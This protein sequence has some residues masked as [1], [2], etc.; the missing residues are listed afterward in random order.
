MH[1]GKPPWGRSAAIALLALSLSVAACKAGAQPN[2]LPTRAERVFADLSQAELVSLEPDAE[3]GAPGRRLHGWLVLGSMPLRP[4]DA[5][6]AAAAMKAAVA[7]SDGS[8]AAC[9]EPRHA[10]RTRSGGHSYEALIC[11][12][13][14]G[15]EVYRD[16]EYVGGA[17]VAGSSDALNRILAAGHVPVSHSEEV[18]RAQ[19]QAQMANDAAARRRWDAAMPASLRA[20]GED[21]WT[22]E[23]G[24][25]LERRERAL[26][27]E[28]PQRPARILALLRWYGSGAGP[29]SGVAMYEELPDLLLHRYPTEEIIR[30]VE[31]AA[32]T[33]AET[34]GAARFFGG[35]ARPRHAALPPALRGRLL[36]QALKSKDEDKAGRA[37]NAFAAHD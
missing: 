6:A 11:Y 34:E 37:R 22:M 17:A 16:G 35:Y 9:F 18:E 2:R 4:A 26:A 27:Q 1:I 19:M 31:S 14:G 7:A 8:I 20:I 29:W 33:E 13:C 32:L 12:S 15:I 24:P 25:D 30:T 5:K 3:P 21:D 28:I 23:H 10:L 36:A